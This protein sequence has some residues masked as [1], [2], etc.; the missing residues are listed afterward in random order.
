MEGHKL[1]EGIQGRH[2]RKAFKE[3]IQGRIPRNKFKEYDKKEK[4]KGRN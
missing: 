3:G 1:K 2:S 4:D